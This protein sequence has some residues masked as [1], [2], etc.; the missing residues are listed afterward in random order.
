M[1]LKDVR[2]RAPLWAR[3][4][5][6]SALRSIVCKL[7]TIS[8]LSTVVHAFSRPWAPPRYPSPK[9]PPSG[10]GLGGRSRRARAQISPSTPPPGKVSVTYSVSRCMC[11][12]RSSCGTYTSK[13]PL[14]CPYRSR[15]WTYT[16]T[17][18]PRQSSYKPGL[19]RKSFTER[20][21]DVQ[22]SKNRRRSS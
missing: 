3:E 4:R 16:S 20:C 2:V 12:Y 21:F 13:K 11:L 8:R 10:R 6:S 17:F 5:I 15:S 9:T 7:L 1:S 18:F 19:C 14:K 22:V